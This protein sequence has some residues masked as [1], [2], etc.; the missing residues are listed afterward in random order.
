MDF[1]TE[2][3][4]HH[5]KLRAKHGALPLKISSELN[6]SAQKWA[7]H[8]N[9]TGNFQ[10]SVGG[11]S[12]RKNV[13]ENLFSSW[14]SDP[15]CKISGD[16]PAKNWYSEIKDYDFSDSEEQIMNKFSKIGHFT[17]LV[18]DETEFLGVGY[19]IK[20]GKCIVVAQYEPAGNM[21]GSFKKHVK[22]V[23]AS[24]S[25]IKKSSEQIE[26]PFKNMSLKS[27]NNF[28]EKCLERHNYYRKMHGVRDL[29][30]CQKLTSDAEKFAKYLADN[31]KFS[32]STDRGNVGESLYYYWTNDP[33]FQINAD[34]IIDGWYKESE[35]YPWKGGNDEVMEEFQEIGHFTQMVWK[36]SEKFGVGYA[37]NGEK[38]I[39]VARYEPSGNVV[40]RFLENVN[41]KS[42]NY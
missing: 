9:Q 35:K 11:E 30:Y 28:A 2:C 20:N 14:S 26:T 31:D 27:S 21:V 38:H 5:N 16:K 23:G 19:V 24:V 34:K 12:R 13:G 3:L 22:P 29:S 36:G 17:Q 25:Q 18:W 15:N 37:R 7:D 40:G 8:L 42:E 32:N 4:N 1:I 10:H 6:K 33:K 39:V 41:Q